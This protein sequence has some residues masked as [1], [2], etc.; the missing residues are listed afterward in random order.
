MGSI[1]KPLT[2]AAAL[3]SGSVTENT[4]YDDQGTIEIS[5][6][7]ISNYDKKARGP[8]TN[9]QTILDKSLNVGIAFVVQRLGG[10][11]LAKYFKKY[12]FGQ[13]TGIDLPGE[14]PG[15]VNNLD[16]TIEVDLVTAGFGQ[17]I[18]L[19]PISTVRALAVLGNGGKLVT[20]HLVDSITLSSGEVIKNIPDEGQQIFEQAS[21]SKIISKMLV[22]VVDVSLNKKNPR[23]TVAAKTGTA[24]VPDPRTQ[25]YSPDKYLHSFFGYF[26]AYKPGYLIFLY[27][28]NPVG[29]EYAS[30]TLKDSF[31]KIVDFLISYYE[32]SP[33][34]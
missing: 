2:M 12:G 13:E 17:G 20:P 8:N 29:A 14:V 21:T 31:F 15:L 9:L 4:T 33:D 25:K 27:Q 7:K 32:V 10:Q 18:A 11:N 30:Q 3:D 28:L 34:R 23:Y 26:P 1:L 16:S 5:G 6:L 24:Q 19:T 22:H